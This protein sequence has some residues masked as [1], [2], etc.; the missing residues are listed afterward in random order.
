M[1]LTIEWKRRIDNWRKELPN[2]FYRT[3]G[4]VPLSSFTTASHE[5]H[6]H[7]DQRVGSRTGSRRHDQTL[8]PLCD[9]VQSYY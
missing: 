5:G 9:C 6:E 8:L 1:A 4:T 3:L 7:E 2:H